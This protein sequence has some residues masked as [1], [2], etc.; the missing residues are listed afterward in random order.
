MRPASAYVGIRRHTADCALKY[1]HGYVCCQGFRTLRAVLSG[2][3]I[4]NAESASDPRSG[5]HVVDVEFD[6]DAARA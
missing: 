5:A 6:D 4:R 1:I 3:Q 2:T